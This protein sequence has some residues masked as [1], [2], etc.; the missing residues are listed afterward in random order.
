MMEAK[1]LMIRNQEY[2]N[3]LNLNWSQSGRGT[4]SDGS[5]FG[6]RK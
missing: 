4:P 2:L 5:E 3:I 1:N 6:R